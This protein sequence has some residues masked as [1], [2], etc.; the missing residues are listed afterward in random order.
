MLR[1]RI[2]PDADQDALG[3]RPR[4]FDGIL[5]QIGDHLVID[6]VGSTPQR[7]FPQCCQ[8]TR[9]EK[10]VGSPAR[11]IG[12]M[13]LGVLQTL[14]QLVGRDIDDDDIVGF[15]DDRVGDHFADGD[16]GDASDDIRQAFD[17]LDIERRPH[18]DAGIEQFLDILE[19][20]GMPA[21]RRIR[22]R[23]FI[24][25]D[26]IGPARQ[27]GIDIELHQTLVLIDDCPGR[28]DFETFEKCRRIGLA[29]RLDEAH[30]NVAAFRLEP[31]CAGEHGIGLA[32][33]G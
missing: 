19:A 2:R 9:L 6:M 14:K 21:V 10:I 12:Q 4:P 15:L 32:D 1:L 30:H 16:A 11:I 29:V 25:D 23:Q 18:I 17:M 27:R 28:Q 3:R 26:E 5:A 8:I 7:Q 20:F 22:M 31:P 24:D 13:D 33:P